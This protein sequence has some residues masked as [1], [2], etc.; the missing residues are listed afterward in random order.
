MVIK[1]YEKYTQVCICNNSVTQ[2]ADIMVDAVSRQNK[3][4]LQHLQA[5]ASI[6]K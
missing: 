2:V 5:V 1:H 6:Y 4:E 3:E